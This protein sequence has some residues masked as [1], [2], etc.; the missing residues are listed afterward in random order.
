MLVRS[1]RLNKLQYFDIFLQNKDIF[2]NSQNVTCGK[3]MIYA[4]EGHSSGH[5][6]Q[7]PA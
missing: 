6:C 7:V 2:E 4:I 5:I 1:W 3:I